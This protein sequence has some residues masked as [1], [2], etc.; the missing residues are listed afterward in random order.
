MNPIRFGYEIK[1]Y[2]VYYEPKMAIDLMYIHNFAYGEGLDGYNDPSDK[3]KNNSVDQYRQIVIGFKYF[4]GT[5]VSYN[6]LI[7]TFD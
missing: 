4:F 1:F 5:V 6:K 2:D 3:F 7:R